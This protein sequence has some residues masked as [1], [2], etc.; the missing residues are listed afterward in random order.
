MERKITINFE[1]K[2]VQKINY[3]ADFDSLPRVVAKFFW[4]K[5]NFQVFGDYKT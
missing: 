1:T 4:P 2:T 3:P 5:T